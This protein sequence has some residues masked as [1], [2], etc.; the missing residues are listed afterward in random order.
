MGVGSGAFGNI[1]SESELK[2]FLKFLFVFT[3]VVPFFLACVVFLV[4]IEVMSASCMMH[5]Y[6]SVRRTYVAFIR[7]SL[8]I[9]RYYKSEMLTRRVLIATAALARASSTAAFVRVPPRS[10]GALAVSSG[11]PIP[12]TSR[13][14]SSDFDPS[15]VP[16]TRINKEQMT[17]ILEDVANG[18]RE[19]SGYCVMDVRGEDEIAYTG[20][21]S[22][23]VETLPLPM[24]MEK[25]AFNMDDDDF[26]E[27]FGFAKPT[28]EE[29]LVFT[30]KAGV[31]STYGAQYAAMAGYTNLVEYMGGADEWFY[32]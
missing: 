26:E 14:M 6:E 30:C 4:H 15:N 16:I 23:V 22:P 7:V 28:M 5:D 29:T 19:D 31:R 24:I 17:E 8:T 1:D 3:R 25:S 21:L 13:Q 10:L 32:R 2:Q 11:S 9:R 20:K 12:P 27:A 18:G